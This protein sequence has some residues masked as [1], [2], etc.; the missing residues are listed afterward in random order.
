MTFRDILALQLCCIT[1]FNPGLVNDQSNGIYI[2]LKIQ[3]GEFFSK[4]PGKI[5]PWGKEVVYLQ[6]VLEK[7]IING[8]YSTSRRRKAA[9]FLYFFF[10]I[11]KRNI[12]CKDVLIRLS[13]IKIKAIKL[14]IDID[15]YR[16]LP[17]VCHIFFLPLKLWANVMCT[18]GK[19]T[20]PWDAEQ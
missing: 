20:I 19:S 12:S 8:L 17:S 18:G 6:F 13:V 9:V 16:C 10:Q 7:A 3:K 11:I 4:G 5:I 14:S 1:Y 15:F 2:L